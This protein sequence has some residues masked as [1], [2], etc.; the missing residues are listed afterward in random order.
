MTAGLIL[1]GSICLVLLLTAEYKQHLTGKLIFKPTLSALFIA[2]AM[3]QP[4]SQT[5]LAAWLLAGLVL[6]WFGDLFLIF[7]S[8]RMF[9]AG[10]VTFL[11]GHLCYAVGFYAHGI[12][13]GWVGLGL[14]G[15]LAVGS[16]IFLWLRPHL[17]SMTGPVIGYIVV[18]TI[19]V[20][21]ALAFFTE[22]HWALN[23][24]T[25]VLVGAVA[26]YLSDILVAR[27]QF[28]APGFVNRLVG[29]PLYYTA[30]FMFAVAVGQV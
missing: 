9:L 27:D 3:V 5:G 25:L 24:R 26:F 18:I 21:G 4:W 19:M 22:T 8:N 15:V 13:N 1:S 16:L 7:P 10:L 28:V 29:L 20:G 6:C 2:T 11:T 14:V 30:Q 23:G 17:G 12:V